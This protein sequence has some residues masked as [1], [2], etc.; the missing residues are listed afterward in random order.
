MAL[1]MRILVAIL[2]EVLILVAI[3][4][5]SCNTWRYCYTLYNTFNLAIS[6]T[7][8]K[9]IARSSIII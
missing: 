5:K 3:I 4:F 7:T 6:S 8:L 2:R 9:E 1:Y